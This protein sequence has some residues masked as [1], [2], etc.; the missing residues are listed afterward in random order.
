MISSASVRFDAVKDRVETPDG[1]T[2][3]CQTAPEWTY[4]PSGRL[5]SGVS[6]LVCVGQAEAPFSL[7]LIGQF[8]YLYTYSNNRITNKGHG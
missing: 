5:V 6:N 1:E 4:W 7:A 2:A 3:R 8:H